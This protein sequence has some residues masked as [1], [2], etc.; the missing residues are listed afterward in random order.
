MN[1]DKKICI[2]NIYHLAKLKDIRIGDLERQCGVSTG[3]LSRLSKEDNTA[4]PGIEFV[5]QAAGILGVSLDSLVTADHTAA[6]ATEEYL[7]GFIGRLISESSRDMLEWVRE[8][9]KDYPNLLAEGGHVVEHPLFDTE[10]DNTTGLY[11]IVYE[12]KFFNKCRIAGDC[13]KLELGKKSDV[14]YLMCTEPGDGSAGGSGC[15]YELYIDSDPDITGI[16]VSTNPV[17]SEILKELYSAAEEAC[18]HPRIAPRV[19]NIIERFM[20][21]RE[22][23]CTM[24]EVAAG[25][26]FNDIDDEDLPF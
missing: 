10:F 18:S 15:C 7:L 8:N 26:I 20:V 2:G 14:L 5:T 9:E 3:T 21:S 6:T 13:Y 25:E 24:E 1:F 4:N 17:F 11:S 19:K 12:S 22:R 23:G 16:A